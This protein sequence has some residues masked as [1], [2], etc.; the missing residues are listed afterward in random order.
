MAA[1]LFVVKVSSL[2]GGAVPDC[3]RAHLQKHGAK[4]RGWRR[5]KS[6]KRHSGVETMA[7]AL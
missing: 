5:A 1:V 7:V 4:R 2:R 6:R 3:G